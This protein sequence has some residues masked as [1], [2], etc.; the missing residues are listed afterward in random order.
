MNTQAILDAI[1]KAAML[2]DDAPVGVF[3]SHCKMTDVD[4]A[5]GN[6]D[7]ISLITTDDID[8]S[9]EVVMADGADWEYL[10]ANRKVFADHNYGLNSA[11]GVLREGYPMAYPSKMLPKGWKAQA[12]IYDKPGMKQLGDD[13]LYMATNGGV[14]V[15]IGFEP[16]EFGPP[17]AEET[18]SR[19]AAGKA[20]P[21]TIHRR[22][23]GLEFSYTAFPCN[24]SCQG[25][26]ATSPDLERRM[27]EVDEMVVK[28]HIH[29]ASAAALGLPITPKRR[30]IPVA[31]VTRRRVVLV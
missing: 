4:Y 19:K 21:R 31:T 14:G 16:V 7:I 11:V 22:W 30:F 8:Q 29:R 25:V 13:I 17:T 2:P 20:V 15:S 27:S 9:D 12:K 1:R 24:V 26:A 28:G 23:K 5:G 18:K 6:R 3:S 10:K